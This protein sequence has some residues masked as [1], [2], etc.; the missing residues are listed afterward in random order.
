[1]NTAAATTTELNHQLL[2]CLHHPWRSL[3][4]IPASSHLSATTVANALVDVSNMMRGHRTKLFSTVD[5]EMAGVS[6]VIVDVAVHVQAGGYAV[7]CVDALV[8]TET[9]IPATLATDA[10]VL[11]V[12]LGVTRI[13][14]A[15]RTME[16]VGE[17][18]FIGAVTIESAHR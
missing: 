4:V 15:K 18:K 10:A 2:R 5:L 13:E 3:A 1:M 8:R 9:G 11:V 17:D 12:H 14:D 6:K 16:L 7:V